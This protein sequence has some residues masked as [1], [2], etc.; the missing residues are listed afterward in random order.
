MTFSCREASV[1]VISVC[2]QVE[3]QMKFGSKLKLQHKTKCMLEE[4]EAH[5][6]SSKGGWTFICSVACVIAEGKTAALHQ[7]RGRAQHL[8]YR[9]SLSNVDTGAEHKLHLYSLHQVGPVDKG[10]LAEQVKI[11]FSV[12]ALQPREHV[13]PLQRAAL[14]VWHT[15][16]S[17]QHCQVPQSPLLYSSPQGPRFRWQGTCCPTPQNVQWQSLGP[18]KPSSSVWNKSVWSC[19]R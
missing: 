11:N 15:T 17:C 19:W 5:C 4:V 18:Q 16:E 9:A 10:W 7:R 14:P 3:I 2:L 8:I 13:K 1:W 6:C 12:L